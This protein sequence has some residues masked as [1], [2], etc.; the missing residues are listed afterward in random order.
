LGAT[1]AATLSPKALAPLK[2]SR[3]LSIGR[4][5]AGAA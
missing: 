2:T 4:A 1:P 3:R 5:G